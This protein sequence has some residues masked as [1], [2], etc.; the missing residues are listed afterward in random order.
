[1]SCVCSLA[2]GPTVMDV[3]KAINR[4][5]RELRAASELQKL[6]ELRAWQ[7]QWALQTL[8][9]TIRVSFVTV[10]NCINLFQLAVVVGGVMLS[11]AAQ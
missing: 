1:M 8:D 6:N 10:C 3:C 7:W 2:E 4:R 11:D 5:A 9:H